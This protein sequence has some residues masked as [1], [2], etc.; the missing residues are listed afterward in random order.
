GGGRLADPRLGVLPDLVAV[1]R[2]DGDDRA[3]LPAPVGRAPSREAFLARVERGARGPHALGRL[4]AEADGRDAAALADL[5]EHAVVIELLD[6][7]DLVRD[8]VGLD[9][10]DV[11]EIG[12]GW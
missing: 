10:V 7:L 5:D 8:R 1:P 12:R 2:G 11:G 4:N 6:A 9:G 3:A